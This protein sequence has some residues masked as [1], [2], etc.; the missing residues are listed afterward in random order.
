MQPLMHLVKR[1]ALATSLALYFTEAVGDHYQVTEIPELTKSP[2]A[3]RT[4]VADPYLC[5]ISPDGSKLLLR[6]VI[7]GFND[8]GPLFIQPLDG[9][10]AQPLAVTAF[11]GSWTP[12]GKAIVFARGEDLSVLDLRTRICST[13]REGKW[14]CVV[15][16]LVSRRTPTTVYGHRCEKSDDSP[17]GG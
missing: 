7:S 5:D 4:A 1:P 14:L 16:A 10:P 2:S 8:Y 6:S 17:M 13:N 12:D 11:D 15:A 3:L 9:K